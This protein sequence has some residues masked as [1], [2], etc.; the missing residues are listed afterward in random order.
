[1]VRKKSDGTG[2]IFVAKLERHQI[3]LRIIGIQPLFQNRMSNKV[4]EGLLVGSRKKTRADRLL[5]KHSPFEEFRSSAEIVNDGPTAL[6][7]RVTA[8]KGAMCSAAIETAGLSK[9]AT[10]RLLFMPG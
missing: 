4:K 9:A 3:K 2:E 10:Q 7:L 6:G 5:I 8:I 1:M